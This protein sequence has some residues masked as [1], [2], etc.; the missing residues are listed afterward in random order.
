MKYG[1]AA[2]PYNFC[3]LNKCVHLSIS[4]NQKC[5]FRYIIL[6]C[7]HRLYGVTT[8][9]SHVNRKYHCFALYKNTVSAEY[10][11]GLCSE[12]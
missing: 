10:L 9:Q 12:N 7:K 8:S 2:T 6:H 5:Q 4:P 11:V 3:L 1:L